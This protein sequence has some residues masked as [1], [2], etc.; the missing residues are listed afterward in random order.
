[1]ELSLRRRVRVFVLLSLVAPIIAA[2]FSVS[3]LLVPYSVNAA[4]TIPYKVNFQGRL[5][6]NSGNILSDGLYNVK[7]RLYDALTAGN[8][9]WEED[10]V[11]GASD[12]RIQVT[13]GLFN[14]QFGDVTVLS[15]ALFSG[16]F[17]LY[18]EVEMP[19]PASSNCATNGCAVFT[20]GA[21]S[22]RQPLAS[23]AYAFNSQTL[24]GI[25]STGFAQ[26]AAT[27]TF[28]AANIF[29]PGVSAVVGLTAKA[30][31]SGG[32]NSLE[33]FD[34]SNAR[35]AFFDAA[36]SLNVGQLI[37]PTSN[38]AIDV[39]TP[40][41]AFRN[42]YVANI[43]TGTT[44]TT[45]S[46]GT[47]QATA[48]TV[49][50]TASSLTL[51]SNATLNIG[52]AA[53]AHT[54]SVGTGA[55]V[56]NT[57][58]IGGTGANAISIG[59]T[60]TG[61]SIA[62][63]NALS[64]GTIQIG[65][66]A[67]AHTIQI[68]AGGAAAGNAELISI[69][70][71]TTTTASEVALQGGNLTATNG[72][73]GVIIGGG[74]STTDTNLVGLTLDS[75]TT[76]AETANTCS[77][78]VNDGTLY[79]NSAQSS[80]TQGGSMAI[81]AC[82]NGG[83]EDV[84]TTAGLGIMLFGVIADTGNNPGDL[85]ATTTVGVSGPCKVSWASATTITI[86]P[87]AAYSG[88]RKVIVTTATLTTTNATAGNMQHVCLTGTNSAPVLMTSS[89]EASGLPTFNVNNPILCLADVAFAAGNNTISQIFDVRTLT[90]S[91]KEFTN[92]AAALGLGWPACPTGKQAT[93]CAAATG[94]SVL[95]VVAATNG[96][97]GAG[98][99]PNVIIVTSGPTMSKP[100]L[101][102]VVAGDVV[103]TV[104]T[105]NRLTATIAA[106]GKIGALGTAFY[107]NLGL[108]QSSSPTIACTTVASAAN[109]DYQ[110][111]FDQQ[112]S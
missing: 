74:Y 97:T 68:G 6:D 12:N 93:T 106:S 58:N 2:I 59:N 79:Y 81:R 38:N 9:K 49:G 60:Q 32:I 98:G 111:F 103:G 19:T 112:K 44:T 67:A 100:N 42:A 72:N 11:F 24:N 101:T 61:G 69:G 108:A 88:G 91:T 47:A 31:T 105:A 23:S 84:V 36:G 86:A 89:T 3:T 40:T 55:G 83:W 73:S 70:S 87:C 85:A 62:I 56:T 80:G 96:A 75:A 82:I 16:V 33:V 8:N 107:S 78:T 94:D 110:L 41:N 35:Q 34:S 30:S 25:D 48:I 15:T 92:S 4:Q 45:L 43:D 50:S 17:P 77:K 28:T 63:G 37:Q 109:C 102:G 1:M 54:I 52:V 20:E 21:M 64:T 13:N 51:E 65:N 46:V 99:V 104:P 57:I 10:R 53:N 95:G 71:G 29:T 27:N 5:T 26:L 76:F 22:P 18:L 66:G 7:F 90:T 14:I 39:G